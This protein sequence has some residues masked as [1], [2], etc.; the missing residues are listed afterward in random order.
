MEKPLIFRII[1]AMNVKEIFGN[2]IHTYRKAKK[3]SQEQL[4][5]KVDISIKHL[6]TLETGK[7]FASAELID[8]IAKALGVSVSALFYTV[9]EKSFDSSDF[10]RI[11][12][13]IEEES[14]KAFLEIKQ[15]MRKERK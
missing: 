9:Q 12:K 11:E 4:A 7:V 1:K 6:S 14:Q 8:K 2:N 15:R 3:W 10:H 5:E 13:I